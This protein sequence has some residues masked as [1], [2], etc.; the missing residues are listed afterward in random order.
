MSTGRLIR[1]VLK[2]LTWSWI[3][4][5]PGLLAVAVLAGRLTPAGAV[6][7]VIWL[8]LPWLA[9]LGALVVAAAVLGPY[10]PR[11]TRSPGGRNL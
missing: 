2:G 11:P 9:V 3:T 5:P 8:V 7:L 10:R 6:D 4:G 1:A